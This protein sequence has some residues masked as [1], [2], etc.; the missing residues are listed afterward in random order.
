MHV[1]ILAAVG[2]RGYGCSEK[3]LGRQARGR[4]SSE[5]HGRLVTL[6]MTI[7]YVLARGRIE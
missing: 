4:E 7:S 5:A 2:A 6:L 3:S 1:A